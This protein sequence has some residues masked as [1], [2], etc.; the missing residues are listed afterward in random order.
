MLIQTRR[1]RVGCLQRS[2]CGSFFH[3]HLPFLFPMHNLNHFVFTLQLKDSLNKR[4]LC[5]SIGD[6]RTQRST[7][8]CYPSEKHTWVIVTTR[9]AIPSN[10]GDEKGD[11]FPLH[12]LFGSGYV[13]ALLPMPYGQLLPVPGLCSTLG[14]FIVIRLLPS[15]DGNSYCRV[16]D[17]LLRSC[18]C[19]V[20]FS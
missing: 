9:I 20:G 7:N 19:L 17:Y 2:P 6:G 5:L 8:V 10:D 18:L 14:G 1:K 13:T 4:C 3:A 12:S 11:L 16:R 15:L